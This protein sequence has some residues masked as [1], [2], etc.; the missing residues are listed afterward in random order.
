MN[1]SRWRVSG[2]S[3][4]LTPLSLPRHSVNEKDP[5]TLSKF[6]LTMSVPSLGCWL[7]MFY[8]LFHLW[9]NILAE[10]TYFGDRQF[11]KAWWNA[12]KLDI[13]W[14]DWNI[15]VHGWLVRH[16]F[17]PCMNAGWSKSASMF[18]V[19][20]VSAVFHEV[21]LRGRDNGTSAFR[22]GTSVRIVAPLTLGRFL[23]LALLVPFAFSSQ[24]LVSVPCHT[25]NWYAFG[26]MMAQ[27]PLIALTSFIEKNFK[28]SQ[29]GNFIFWLSFTIIG[30]PL[31]IL[32]YFIEVASKN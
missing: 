6:V 20:F 3:S 21:R 13:Y 22:S 18:I 27:V 29:V 14:R 7:C 16:L 15:P 9:L 28:E 4:S 1:S 11:Y 24:V 17:M 19:F 30:Q 23:L 5:L 2:A 26:G 12:T 10:L 8:A 32:L 25:S 31:C